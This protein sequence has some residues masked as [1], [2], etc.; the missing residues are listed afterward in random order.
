MPL[1]Q[2]FDTPAAKG[3]FYTAE[4]LRFIYRDPLAYLHLLYRK[5]RLFWNAFEIPV[6][7]DLRYY[8][9]HF[10]LYRLFLFSF[11]LSSALCLGRHIVALAMD[12]CLYPAAPLRSGLPVHWALILG[13]RSLSF[14]CPTPFCWFLPRLEFGV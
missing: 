5:F 12:L 4:G 2:G 10:P 8:E 3:A 1:Q 6:S 9:T 7:A 11:G 14:A 13:M